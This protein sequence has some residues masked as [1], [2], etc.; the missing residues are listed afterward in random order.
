MFVFIIARIYDL[1]ITII[2]FSIKFFSFINNRFFLY[3]YFSFAF[4]LKKDPKL[5]LRI[6]FDSHGITLAFLS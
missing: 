6:S 2:Q 4:V 1:S 3:T 5:A